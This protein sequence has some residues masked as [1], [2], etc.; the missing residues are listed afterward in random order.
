MPLLLNTNIDTL[1]NEKIKGTVARVGGT[2]NQLL[3]YEGCVVEDINLPDG[4]YGI[5]TEIQKAGNPYQMYKAIKKIAKQEL[6]FLR[7]GHR[8]PRDR[9]TL[10]LDL[11]KAYQQGS[12]SARYDCSISSNLIEHSPNPVFL[13]LNFYYITKEAGYQYHAIPHYKYTFDIYRNPT[14]LEHFIEDFEN[15]ATEEDSSHREDYRQSAVVKHGWQRDFHRKYPVSYPYMHY[16]V[17]DEVN[18]RQLA[19]FMFED[20]CND[21]LKDDEFSDNVVIFRNR[22]NGNFCR[23]YGK[24]IDSYLDRQRVLHS[25]QKA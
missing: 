19:E 25:V 4:G 10:I 11:H 7:K 16:H 18:V 24:I 20:V 15:R 23:R 6:A 1:V 22:L 21:I 8:M 9:R 5:I 3:R 13:L 12:L 2:V 14:T 17:F